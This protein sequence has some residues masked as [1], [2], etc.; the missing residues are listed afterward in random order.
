MS[1]V[2]L[3]D[4]RQRVEVYMLKAVRE[5]KVHTS[6]INV[7]E[8]YEDA[9]KAF[10]S[11]LLARSEN[12]AFLDDLIERARLL[13]RLGMLNSLSQTLLKLTAPGVPDIYRG[14]ETADLSL[15][16]P[17][18]RR[19]VDYARLGRLLAAVH[20]HDGP[21]ESLLRRLLET[22]EDGRAKLFVTWKLLSLRRRHP[23]VFADGGYQALSVTGAR[24]DHICA[25]ARSHER[26]AFV[27][28]AP[29]LY[30]GLPGAGLTQP[31]GC[32]VWS[33]T[34]VQLDAPDK[35]WQE[36]FSN[37]VLV[38]TAAGRLLIGEILCD[39]PIALL[40]AFD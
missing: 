17:D 25:F 30:G 3:D 1:Q 4:Y 22:I 5:A 29:R 32:A 27:V 9:L 18:N 14:T 13:A 38:G 12:N 7:N 21:R 28:V 36:L 35:P 15:V 31:L 40:A 11:T 34:A 33:D 26:G 2:E 20:E 10:V 19:P 24:A 39:F 16:D 23:E 8:A 37:R 6:W